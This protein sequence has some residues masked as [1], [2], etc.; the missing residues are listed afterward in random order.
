[1]KAYIKKHRGMTLLMGILLLL[2]MTILTI[3]AV[4]YRSNR[5]FVQAQ[6]EAQIYAEKY[7]NLSEVQQ[8]YWFNREQ[9]YYSFTGT[10]T[11]GKEIAVIIPE[12]VDKVT[13]LNQQDGISENQAKGVVHGAYPEERITKTSLGIHEEQAVWE[14]VTAG[15]DD[16]VNYYLV[17][18]TTGE[19]LQEIRDI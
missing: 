3:F 19:L 7:A 12:Q 15:T 11:A 13:V 18:F 2:V 16:T 10:D 17:S 4:F 1:M 6:E 14:V 9:S 5:P 8:F